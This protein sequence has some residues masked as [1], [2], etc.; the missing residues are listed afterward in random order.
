MY[1]DVSDYLIYST[2]EGIYGVHT[3]PTITSRPFP[4]FT[5]QSQVNAFD[6]SDENST[7]IVVSSEGLMKVALGNDVVGN[8]VTPINVSGL[9]YGHSRQPAI[10]LVHCVDIHH[11]SEKSR[12]LLSLR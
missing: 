6:L 4:S 8:E 5:S 9:F 12:P 11:V 7:L 3:D 10:S 2:S 1:T